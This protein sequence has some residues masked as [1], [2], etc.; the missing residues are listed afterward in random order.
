MGKFFENLIP[1]TK[2]GAIAA[3]V[4][5][6]IIAA[7]AYVAWSYASRAMKQ[8]RILSR[9]VSV[10]CLHGG[11]LA[12]Q[13]LIDYHQARADPE[14]SDGAEN[15]LNTLLRDK[16]PDFWK[17]RVCLHTFLSNFLLKV[18]MFPTFGFLIFLKYVVEYSKTF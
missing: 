6:I 1:K 14:I 4:T 11:K 2:Y 5:P 16:H 18:N 10:G 15:E 13:R 8:Q 17:L 9:S 3:T 7:G 12:L